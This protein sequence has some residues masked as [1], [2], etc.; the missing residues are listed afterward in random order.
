MAEEKLIDKLQRRMK[1][2]QIFSPEMQS[3]YRS[4]SHGKKLHKDVLDSITNI[5]EERK[6]SL[7]D[8]AK[9]KVHKKFKGP[10]KKTNTMANTPFRLRGGNS[11][12][13]ANSDKNN[14]AGGGTDFKTYK[15]ALFTG[16]RGLFQK[17]K[18]IVKKLENPDVRFM[19]GRPT[20]KK[21]WE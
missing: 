18:Q 19:R 8:E 15:E 11:P 10:L 14:K 7:L 4:V 17:G 16:M 13:Q 9:K 1:E 21:W 12:F 6:K 20:G 5:S 3:R 2:T